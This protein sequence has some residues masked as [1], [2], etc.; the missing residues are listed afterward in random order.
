MREIE[1]S[2]ILADECFSRG[3][4]CAEAVLRGACHAQGV[5]LPDACLRM[6]T[7]FGG[8]VGRSEDLCGALSGGVL[9]IGACLGRTDSKEDK[10]KSYGAAKE[11]FDGFVATEG[12]PKCSVL[13]KGEFG[14]PE[15][16]DRCGRFVR[17]ATRI[18]IL[19]I[20]ARIE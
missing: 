6:A 15:H 17:D 13:N 14:T 3:Y 18:A 5:T 9:A 1:E 20:R 8:G 12:S 4:N 7:P 11:F 19:A 2:V 10:T 16:R